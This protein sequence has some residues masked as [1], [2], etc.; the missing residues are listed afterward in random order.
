MR[1]LFIGR[2]QPLHDGHI[3]IIRN[4]LR[5][6]KPVLIALRDTP[7]DAK[8]PYSIDERKTMIAQAFSKGEDVQVVAIPDISE[9][10]YGRDVGYGITEI[11]PDPLTRTISASKIREAKVWW[12]TGNSKSGKTTLS[13]MMSD[14]IHLDGDALRQIWT[15]GFSKDDRW[16]QNLRVA[17]LA[18][19]LRNQGH[20][21]VIST[22][23]PYRELRQVVQAICGCKFIYIE[24][25]LPATTEYPYEWPEADGL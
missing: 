14:A 16:E 6:G 5:E 10:C 15:L 21:V 9:V 13:A 22:I 1:S 12:L 24:G 19:L 20:N 25:G 18:R 23:C 11:E 2:Y 4:K 3:Q 17:K 8:N 7:K